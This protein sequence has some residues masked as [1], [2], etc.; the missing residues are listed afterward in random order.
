[1]DRSILKEIR[2]IPVIDVHEHLICDELRIKRFSDYLSLVFSNYIY[3]NA[4]SAGMAWEDCEYIMGSSNDLGKKYRLFET[5]MSQIR[6]TSVFQCIERAFRDIYGCEVCDKNYEKVNEIFLKHNRPGE[7]YHLIK[8]KTPIRGIINDVYDVSMQ[9]TELWV[10]ERYM[11]PAIRC[12]KYILFDQN[13][14]LI[15]RENNGRLDS[16]KKLMDIQDEYIRRAMSDYHGSALKLA[17]AYDRSLAFENVNSAEAEAAFS[18]IL[19]QRLRDEP[20]SGEHVC[21]VQDYIVHQIMEYAQEFAVPVQIHT[22]FQDRNIND[23]RRSNPEHLIP[24]F[25]QYPKVRFVLFHTGYPHGRRAAVLAKMFSNVFVDFSW[26][27]ILSGHYAKNMLHEYIELVPINKIAV[28]GGDFFHREGLYGH[29]QMMQENLAAVMDKLV[30]DGTINRD[31]AV[32]VCAKLL[33]HNPVNLY[34]YN[35]I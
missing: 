35:P 34:K 25:I 22:G 33:Y 17:V 26:V 8:E 30:E 27:H 9:N 12:D 28:F 15:E 31:D 23:P 16:L 19:S 6:L 18:C 10:D 1:M 24:L 5:V 29:L 2:K 7:T 3:G 11:R 4:V 20:L 13:W 32:S 14:D 21:K